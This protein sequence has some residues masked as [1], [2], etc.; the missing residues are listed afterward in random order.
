[1]GP[2]LYVLTDDSV[3][4]VYWNATKTKLSSSKEIR[5]RW[6]TYSYIHKHTLQLRWIEMEQKKGIIVTQWNIWESEK[7]LCIQTTYIEKWSNVEVHGN[8]IV[9]ALI[10]FNDIC[11]I[12]RR[13]GFFH[14]DS[15]RNVY[16]ALR[17]INSHFSN[18]MCRVEY[19]LNVSK[20]WFQPI[21]CTHYSQSNRYRQQVYS[22]NSLKFVSPFKRERVNESMI[23][24][25]VNILNRKTGKCLTGL[26]KVFDLKCLKM[27]FKLK[28]H[29]HELKHAFI[30]VLTDIHRGT[31]GWES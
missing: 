12:R 2:F 28:Q 17:I 8:Q 24:N 18:C 10:A 13:P 1:M 15:F 30:C 21:N 5:W 9:S 26:Q 16:N 6:N 20:L 3:V 31:H 25:S 4:D 23:V 22:L 7:L 14:I 11:L 27:Y 29:T 19:C